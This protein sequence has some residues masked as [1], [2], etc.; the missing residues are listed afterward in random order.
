MPR[1]YFASPISG[2]TSDAPLAGIVMLVICVSDVL[3]CT[4]II[5]TQRTA[6]LNGT[7]EGQGGT[8]AT[9][10]RWNLSHVIAL[11][12]RRV[13]AGG[14]GAPIAPRDALRGA[15]LA[16]ALLL[17]RYDARG[18]VVT[19]GNESVLSAFAPMLLER[20]AATWLCV[21][22][23]AHVTA[24]ELLGALWRTAALTPGVTIALAH[25]R[26]SVCDQCCR[27]RT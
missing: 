1:L 6:T 2:V 4:H 10:L 16:L 21:D 9:Q 7:S 5:I 17:R 25:E 13:G 15:Y 24:L 3:Y 18:V 8:R 14:V 12:V 27:S 11:L 22:L 23:E 26:E 19:S 20:V